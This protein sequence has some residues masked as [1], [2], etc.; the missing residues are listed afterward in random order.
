MWGTSEAAAFRAASTAAFLR[1]IAGDERA[2]RG[3]FRMIDI[4][5]RSGSSEVTFA[6]V[7]VS[8]LTSQKK[9]PVRARTQTHK[10]NDN[11]AAAK[12]LDLAEASDSQGGP[13]N[14]AAPAR[15]AGAPQS[16]TA[17][18]VRARARAGSGQMYLISTGT[19]KAAKAKRFGIKKAWQKM[20][21]AARIGAGL[22]RW[23]TR[24]RLALPAKAAKLALAL[25][26]AQAVATRISGRIKPDVAAMSDEDPAQSARK[27]AAS[28][29]SPHRRA[30]S[31]GPGSRDPAG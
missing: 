10:S 16:S 5:R 7:K 4:A 28:P 9:R 29:E 23:L 26:S 25:S 27:R 21:A 11:E 17:T 30:R 1:E 2:R 22:L 12:G 18:P 20:R 24:A 14:G 13:R 6:G 31:T 15:E 19:W 8:A 3:A